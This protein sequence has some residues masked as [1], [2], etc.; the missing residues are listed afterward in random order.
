M[1]EAQAGCV[2]QVFLQVVLT[3]AAI[4][5]A[6]HLLPAGH[7][8]HKGQVVTAAVVAQQCFH[9]GWGEGAGVTGQGPEE[10]TSGQKA[11]EG[12]KGERRATCRHRV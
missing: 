9:L 3:G 7:R 10:A 5:P 1:D 12:R 6:Q 2:E 4:L 11:A 8:P